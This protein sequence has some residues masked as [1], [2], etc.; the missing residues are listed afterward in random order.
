MTSLAA[1]LAPWRV[2]R[3]VQDFPAPLARCQSV[4]AP[5]ANGHADQTQGRVPDM[6]GHAPDL[7]VAPLAEGKLQPGRDRVALRVHWWRAFRQAAGVEPANLGWPGQAILE[8]DSLTQGSE[9]RLVGV[10][11]HL[12]AIRF[13]LLVAR[14]ADALNQGAI[15]SQQQQSF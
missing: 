8:F 3:G 2:A 4:Q 7:A 5:G 11:L 15:I 9:C 12:H 13:G 10:A 1:R 14:V 6:R